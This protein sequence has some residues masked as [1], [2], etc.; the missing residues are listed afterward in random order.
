[1]T[2]NKL[3]KAGTYEFRVEPF[4]CDFR[5]N[6]FMGHLGNAMLNAADYHSDER[7]YGISYLNKIRKTWVLSRLA[8]EMKQ[9]P[10]AY[11]KLRISTWVDNVMRFFTSR[12]FEVTDFDGQTLGFGRSIWAMIDTETREPVDILQVR[13]GLIS[14]YIDA[15]HKCPIAKPSRVVI[16][17]GARLANSITA[18][19]SDVDVNGHVNSIKYIDHVLD[20][21]D[22]EWYKTHQIERIDVAFVAEAHEGDKLNF[23]VHEKDNTHFLI[24]ITKSNTENMDEEEVCRQ[25]IKFIPYFD[26]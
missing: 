23:Y 6:L 8:I 3:P 22:L 10:R 26:K 19:Y 5:H 7:G 14:E 2:T 9:M 13:D 11:N 15:D 17:E 21:W 18:R 25:E 1:M 24:K 4:H 12:N 20:L 16:G